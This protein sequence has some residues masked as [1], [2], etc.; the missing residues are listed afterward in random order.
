MPAL[1]ALAVSCQNVD[2]TALSTL[3]Q[4][5]ALREL[6]P[7]DFKDEGFRHVGDCRRLQRLSC[8]Y[9]RE[10]TD[11][12]TE[13]ITDLQLKS[14]YA[15]LTLITDRSL[16][17]L[18]RM[19]SLESVEFWETKSVTDAGLAHLSSL[20]HLREVQI[21][22]LPNVTLKGTKVFPPHVV[23]KYSPLG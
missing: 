8:M 2:N 10:T 4:F 3:P 7:I 16:E 12:A 11:R 1:R 14:Y 15:G 19:V 18:G 20:P 22:G 9:C 23:V 6:T 5:P 21:A 17:I 13:Y